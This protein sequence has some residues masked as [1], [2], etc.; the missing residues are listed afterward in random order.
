MAEE[1]DFLARWSRRKAEA[2][3]AGESA[4][5][6]AEAPPVPAPAAPPAG[7]EATAPEAVERA[8][9]PPVDSLT[10]ES[11]FSPFMAAGVDGDVRR[12]ALKALFADPRFNAMDMLDVY[13]D[14]YSKPDPLP[15][16]WLEKLEQ[17]SRLGDRA[18]RDLEEARRR[19]A[20][21][22]AAGA[23]P[24]EAEE[25]A[26]QVDGAAAEAAGQPAGESPGSGAPAP[27]PTEKV[28]KSAT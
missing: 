20:E 23:A 28:G 18:G 21:P 27:I 6:P 4:A 19:E 25:P 2:R 22:G 8:P 17:V 24:P 15:A 7:G 3:K 13:V 26:P 11:D 12:R 5:T 10:P 14:D 9:L 1:G 16:S